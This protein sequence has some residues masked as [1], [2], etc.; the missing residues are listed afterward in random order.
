M[1][2]EGDRKVSVPD[3]NNIAIKMLGWDITET[4]S[5]FQLHQIRKIIREELKEFKIGVKNGR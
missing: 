1:T 5:E 4:F 3:L 2:Y